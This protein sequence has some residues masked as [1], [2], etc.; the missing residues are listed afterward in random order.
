MERIWSEHNA[1]CSAVAAAPHAM[2]TAC[3]TRSGYVTAHSR[4]RCPPIEPP[5]THAH[6]SMPSASARAA[7]TAIWSRIVIVGNCEPYGAPVSGLVDDGPVDPWQPPK[8]FGATT[9]N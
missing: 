8:T 9:K 2:I 5:T 1:I 3:G 7:S 4:A 6:R